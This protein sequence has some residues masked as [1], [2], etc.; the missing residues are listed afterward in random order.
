MRYLERIVGKRWLD[1]TWD[2]MAS[3]NRWDEM[4]DSLVWRECLG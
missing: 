1:I 3:Q 4:V 2:E